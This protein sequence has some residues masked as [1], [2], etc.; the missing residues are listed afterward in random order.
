[1]L[2]Q[3]HRGISGELPDSLQSFS[4]LVNFDCVQCSLSGSIPA[5]IGSWQSIQKIALTENQFDGSLPDG[6]GSLPMLAELGID[7]NMLTGDLS[8][9]GSVTT[10]SFLYAEHN[11]FSETLNSSFLQSLTNLVILDISDNELAG[12]VPA[13]LMGNPALKVLDIHDNSL[14]SFPDSIPST[15][16][17]AFFAIHG[18]PLTGSFPNNTIT[19]LKDTLDH[20]D[21]T[22]TEFVGGMPTV[23]GEMQKLEYLFM[24]DTTF[25]AGPIPSEYENLAFLRDLSLKHSGRTGTIPTW[26][27]NLDRVILLDLDSNDFT[28][29]IPSE[30][31]DMV[32]LQFLLLNR[33]DLDGE[34][35]TELGL[36]TDLRK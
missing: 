1:M 26:I 2:L 32:G 25:D 9:L 19:N 5:W 11:G 13:H 24:A 35:P 12:E 14:T 29:S 18:N 4:K 22:S 8:V 17:L 21:L 31:S 27:G 7:D 28:G 16:T 36:A 15:G 10:L 3:Q 33:N 34:I 20:F 23:L 6:M 30:I